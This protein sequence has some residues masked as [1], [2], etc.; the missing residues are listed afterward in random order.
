MSGAVEFRIVKIHKP[1][2][3]NMV[4]GQSHFIKTV[5]DISEAVVGGVPGA[6]FGLAFCEASGD[7]L[8]R[9]DGNDTDLVALARDN[10][11]VIG[12]GHSFVLFLRD[13][14]PVNVLNAIKQVPEVCT[15]F[16]ATANAAEV[17]VAESAQG[18]GIM[19]VIDG[20]K[21]RGIE[22]PA[23]MTGRKE[24]LRKLGYKRG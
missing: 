18:R 12:A 15:I 9:L 13:C 20:E 21:P 16:C 10:A 14:Y 8:I 3:V 22:D 2:D 6:R 23:G 5:E 1:E 17:I 7:C 11:R 24:F 19:G 4:L